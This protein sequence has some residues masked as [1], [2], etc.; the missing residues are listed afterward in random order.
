KFPAELIIVEN[1]PDTPIDIPS[2]FPLPIKFYNNKIQ[3]GLSSNLN[4]AFE[5]AQGEYFRT[6]NP[7]V[8]FP[9]NVFIPLIKKMETD[10]IDIIGP[11]IVDHD[12]NIQDSFRSLSKFYTR[13][14]GFTGKRLNVVLPKNTKIIYPDWLAGIFLMMR[15]KTF[16]ELNGFNEKY[17]LYFEDVDFSCRAKL[18]GNSIAVDAE[19]HIIHDAQRKSRKNLRFFFMHVKS[20]LTFFTSKVY[21]DMK[22]KI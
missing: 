18:N 4:W 11:L 2:D 7:D 16:R 3:K 6:L 20:A 22:K 10:S 14:V 19:T 17:F 9:D 5:F 12:D 13:I 8:I 15:S 21:W 1:I